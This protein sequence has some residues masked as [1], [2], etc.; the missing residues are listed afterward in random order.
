MNESENSA[1]YLSANLKLDHLSIIRFYN[2]NFKSDLI[3]VHG[4]PGYNLGIMEYFI[5]NEKFCGLVN[6]FII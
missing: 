2:Q 3:F 5:E 6:E 1:H 4:G